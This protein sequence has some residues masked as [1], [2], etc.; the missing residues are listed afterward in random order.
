M[1][2]SFPSS[3]SHPF[4]APSPTA[5]RSP[6][7]TTQI[8]LRGIWLVIAPHLKTFS[9]QSLALPSINQSRPKLHQ[10]NVLTEEHHIANL[11]PSAFFTLHDYDSSGSWTS[12][13]IRRTYG[14]D[15][16]SAREIDA[17]KKE[18]VVKIVIDIFDKDG[19]GVISREEWMDGWVKEGKRLPDFGVGDDFERQFDRFGLV[20]RR[21]CFDVM[22][23]WVVEDLVICR[24]TAGEEAKVDDRKL[25]RQWEDGVGS[26]LTTTLCLLVLRWAISKLWGPQLVLV[27]NLLTFCFGII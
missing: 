13:E 16:E 7:P 3:F 26:R 11:D 9:D 27:T 10:T 25:A 23:C 15:D 22:G 1:P 8:G 20:G 24:M 21:R 18:D 19:D 17:G 4:L 12:E 6:S 2:P 14:L 5:T